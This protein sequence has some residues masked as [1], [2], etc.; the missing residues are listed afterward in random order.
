MVKARAH[1]EEDRDRE[2]KQWVATRMH[3]REE[4]REKS[5]VRDDVQELM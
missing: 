2:G 5:M 1:A 4:L 3:D